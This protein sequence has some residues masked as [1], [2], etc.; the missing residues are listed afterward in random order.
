MTKDDIRQRSRYH[1]LPT[2]DL[3]S[4]ACLSSRF[5][6]GTAIT[7]EALARIEQAEKALYDFGFRVI[8]VRHYGDMA[9]L[10]L[11]SD[12]IKRLGDD[13]FRGRVV[14]AIK[15]AGYKYVALDL[16]GYRT[17]SMN[18]V[19]DLESRTAP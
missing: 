7:T 15:A 13:E 11:G 3:P 8:R 12:E 4:F 17:G 16:E 19:L 18:E 9:R 2:W 10:E 14:T 6:Y 1:D 5:P